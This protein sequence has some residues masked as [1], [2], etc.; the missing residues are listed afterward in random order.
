[1]SEFFLTLLNRSITAG[2]VILAIMLFRLLFRQ[3]PRRI[4][5]VLWVV[6]ALRLILPFSFES[7][8]SLIPSAETVSPTILYSPAPTVTSGIQFVDR[9][10]NPIL[11]DTVAPDPTGSVNPLQ[12]VTAMLALFWFFGM[13]AFL[14]HGIIGYLRLRR[15]VASAVPYE[16]AGFS[17]S[18]RQS[19]AVSSP[20]I[21]GFVKPKIYLPFGMEGETLRAVLRHEATHI[22]RGDPIVKLIG[23]LLVTVYWFHPLVWLGYILFCRDVELAC[24]EAV[25]RDTDLAGRKRYAEA[26]LACRMQ[27]P[28][29]LGIPLAFGEVGIGVR[30]KRSLAMR[31]PVIWLVVLSI[32]VS[33]ILAGCLLTDPIQEK[34][35]EDDGY[36]LQDGAFT[37]TDV[38]AGSTTDAVSLSLITLDRN[39][40]GNIR[41]Q[42]KL[43]NH[44]AKEVVYGATFYLQI[45][46]GNEWVNSPAEAD[47][48]FPSIAYTLGSYGSETCSYL[49]DLGYDVSRDGQYRLLVPVTVGKES[50]QVWLTFSVLHDGGSTNEKDMLWL[51]RYVLHDFQSG[52]ETDQYTLSCSGFRRSID[53][54]VHLSAAIHNHTEE[55]A[56]AG[57]AFTMQYLNGDVWE[58]AGLADGAYVSFPEV[59]LIIE[60]G[61]SI[62]M[63]YEITL[64]DLSRIGTYRLLIHI[65]GQ[66]GYGLWIEFQIS[67]PSDDDLLPGLSMLLDMTD[68]TIEG[69]LTGKTR[70]EICS[71][72]GNPYETV[73][74][75]EYYYV[76]ANDSILT[77]ALRYRDDGVLSSAS[78]ER[79]A[80]A[81]PTKKSLT[82]MTD[83]AIRE[84]LVGQPA[85]ALRLSWG[86][87]N[88]EYRYFVAYDGRDDIVME[89]SLTID[90]QT[91]RVA[92]VSIDRNAPGIMSSE[93][94]KT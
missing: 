9:F 22:R 20:F 72:W 83:E 80:Y 76:V 10:V 3:A 24:D 38:I 51:D 71:R 53:G 75:N 59:A 17:Y 33:A 92:S 42:T 81:L 35:G 6:A 60:P 36:S 37:M 29:F 45:R 4:V 25:L 54:S 63:S 62:G 69:L 43:N 64:F 1:M 2:W 5:C 50:H 19:E 61:K 32:L 44:G 30:I 90:S 87:R 68:E 74:Q 31:K 23:W 21:L 40:F 16:A 46:D 78:V 15:R 94:E 52:G 56:T 7:I 55:E 13:I 77:L 73:G 82:S 91:Q 58:S 88:G 49:L 65:G 26:L 27:E 8:I 11:G 70:A 89:V 28:R 86:R 79:T 67:E 14:L 57:Y 48:V 18:I 41:M 39:E 84:S 47:V 85:L 66:S 12:I 34:N 93:T